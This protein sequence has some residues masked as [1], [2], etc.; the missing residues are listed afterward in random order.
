MSG[1]G[2]AFRP[3]PPTAAERVDWPAGWGTRFLVFVDVEEEF[4]WTAP[5]DR[6]RH[7]TTAMRAFPAAHRRFADRG[8]PL[9]CMV[10]HPVATDP[11]AA[12]ILRDVV[13]DG[14]SAIGAQ[15]HAWVT[16]PHDEALTPANSFPGNLPEAL[17][18]AKI[19][20]LTAAIESAT[21]VPPT[22]YRAGRY[23]IGPRTLAL[24]RARGY[25]IDSSMRARYSYAEEGGPD[26][27]AIGAHAFRRDGMVELPLTTVFTGAL[28]RHGPSLYGALGR[29]PKGRGAAARLGLLSR[30]ALTPEGMPLAD[31]L[32][33]IDVAVE[34]GVRLLSLSFH[35]PSLVPGFTPYVRS[36]ADLA[37][38]WRWWDAVLDRLSLRGIAPTTL[39][40]VE[41]AT[42]LA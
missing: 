11:A 14:R 12:A 42:V 28:R 13:A 29:L 15:L 31:A 17:E 25:R 40:E 2:D 10:D 24:L 16:P 30:V 41:A 4:D 21:G 37:G 34:E 5:P 36:D 27:G 20:A 32:A 7:A 26:F 9:A 23:G 39:A 1:A 8:V 18:A 22:A 33:A 6:M 19:D 38:F 3:T 35:S